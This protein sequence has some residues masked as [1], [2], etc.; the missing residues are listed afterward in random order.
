MRALD[1]LAALDFDHCVPSHFERGS[2]ADYL[3]FRQMMVDYRA[4]GA[5]VVEAM[6]GEPSRG[7]QMR[8]HFG[9]A[10]LA[11][12]AKYGAWRGFDAMFVPHLVWQIGGTYLG[13]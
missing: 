1:R 8:A 3:E 9:Q 10:Y 5:A 6:G 11:L 12:R 7:V 13:Y 2:K 4:A